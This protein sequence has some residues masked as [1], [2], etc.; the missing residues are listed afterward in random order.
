MSIGSWRT[1]AL[2]RRALKNLGWTPARLIVAT[3]FVDRLFGMAGR[4]TAAQE[5]KAVAMAFPRCR[6][7]HTCFMRA[8][9]DIAFI[10][11]DGEVLAL[12]RSVPPWRFRSRRGAAAVLERFATQGEGGVR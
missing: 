2:I 5:G 9:I 3:G 6:A 7:V 4:P 11:A 10:G 1:Y 8:P 12:H